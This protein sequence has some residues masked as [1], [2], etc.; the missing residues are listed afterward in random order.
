MDWTRCI[1]VKRTPLRWGKDLRKASPKPGCVNG[2]TAAYRKK[3]SWRFVHLSCMILRDKFRLL[4]SGYEISRR[5]T[6]TLDEPEYLHMSGLSRGIST[7]YNSL[8][9]L[10]SPTKLLALFGNQYRRRSTDQ[11]AWKFTQAGWRHT[12]TN[13]L[14]IAHSATIGIEVDDYRANCRTP[15]L[16]S[17]SAAR[18]STALV[19]SPQRR[20]GRCG[21]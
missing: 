13:S 10:L 21:S 19:L 20:F 12:R 1:L 8:H 4:E 14:P 9:S 17:R 6:S 16:G 18:R 7:M 15:A 3:Y 2:D 11:P 5:C